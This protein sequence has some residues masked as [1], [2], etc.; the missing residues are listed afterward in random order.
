ME[1]ERKER[2]TKAT[3]QANLKQ[4]LKITIIDFFLLLPFSVFCCLLIKWIW[5]SAFSR[6][7][8]LLSCLLG[9]FPFRC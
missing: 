6:D 1:E 2:L 4:D 3:I 9:F 7:G 8:L 5:D